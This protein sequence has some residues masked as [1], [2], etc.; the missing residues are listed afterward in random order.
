MLVLQRSASP[1]GLSCGMH[2]HGISA[3]ESRCVIAK[4]WTRYIPQSIQGRDFSALLGFLTPIRGSTSNG[5][6]PAGTPPPVSDLPARSYEEAA[7]F[8]R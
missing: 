7:T 6:A 2:K 8:Q 3:F 5:G 4:L 1:N